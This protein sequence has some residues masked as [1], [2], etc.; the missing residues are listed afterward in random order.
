MALLL[1]GWIVARPAIAT[2]ALD[3]VASGAEATSA[4]VRV[5]PPP[6]RASSS[7]LVAFVGDS[8]G[9]FGRAQLQTALNPVAGHVHFDTKGGRSIIANTVELSGVQT[10][11]ALKAQGIFPDVWIV[12]LGTND[13]SVLNGCGCADRVAASVERIRKLLT[14]I[15]P[16]Q[17]VLWVNVENFLFTRSTADYNQALRTLVADGEIDAVTDWA[18]M[19]ASEEDAWFIDGKHLT[20]TGYTVWAH[21]IAVT[22][23][24]NS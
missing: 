23:A 10:V 2:G 4:A 15:G 11:N 17:H 13:V 21:A 16:G 14:A 19:S 5:D 9:T 8:L 6:P 20:P 3:T 18:S 12:E 1:G 22:L 24:A 7:K